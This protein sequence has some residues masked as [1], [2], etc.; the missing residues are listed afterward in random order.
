MWGLEHRGWKMLLGHL[1]GGPQEMLCPEPRRA[2]SMTSIGPCQT[3]SLLTVFGARPHSAGQSHR[4]K[5]RVPQA[6]VYREGRRSAGGASAILSVR[7][8]RIEFPL[9]G[10]G[11]HMIVVPLP[12]AGTSHKHPE[13]GERTMHRDVR[14]LDRLGGASGGRRSDAERVTV[15]PGEPADG[16]LLGVRSARR[17]RGPVCTRVPGQACGHS[18]WDA[19][20]YLLG[21][22]ASVGGA[23]PVPRMWNRHEL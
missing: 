10:V 9:R 22:P 11:R 21:S 14:V 16:V 15:A 18:F 3:C 4:L 17:R 7:P 5:Q 13:L 6:N 1:S 23:V 20:L 2:G 19:C 8:V 12:R